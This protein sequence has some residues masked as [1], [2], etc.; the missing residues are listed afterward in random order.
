VTEIG[1]GRTHGS[2]KQHQWQGVG[3]YQ[4]VQDRRV[5]PPETAVSGSNEAEQE[6]DRDP[7][8]APAIE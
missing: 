1:A 6:G 7:Q 4:P 8:S 5:F 2:G 3:Q